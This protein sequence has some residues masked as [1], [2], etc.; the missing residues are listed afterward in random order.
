MPQET[1]DWI[2]RLPPD[3]SGAEQFNEVL[4]AY[5]GFPAVASEIEQVAAIARADR[6]PPPPAPDEDAARREVDEN[7]MADPEIAELVERLRAVVE[8]RRAEAVSKLFPTEE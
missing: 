1:G 2:A 5:E 4:R 7:L 8:A 3:L 6:L